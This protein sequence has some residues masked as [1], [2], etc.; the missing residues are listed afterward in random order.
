MLPP[1]SPFRAS[2][3]HTLFLIARSATRCKRSFILYFGTLSSLRR[4]FSTREHPRGRDRRVRALCSASRVN[5]DNGTRP[6]WTLTRFVSI[7]NRYTMDPVGR[8][9]AEGQS[10]S[11]SFFFCNSDLICPYR[12]FMSSRILNRSWFLFLISLKLLH[13]WDILY[14]F[15]SFFTETFCPRYFTFISRTCGFWQK[16]L[17]RTEVAQERS[18]PS[19][20]RET[21]SKP[22][23]VFV[24][25]ICS[26]LQAAAHTRLFSLFHDVVGFSLRI[27][28]WDLF[29]IADAD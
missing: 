28:L 26:E 21:R 5:Y 7:G 2:R 9:K 1:A 15:T 14:S 4:G 29:T 19:E 22:S 13:N 3:L 20:N 27:L 16:P 25:D 24:R 6:W 17:W 12:K 18:R 10:L 8:N 23:R 11:I